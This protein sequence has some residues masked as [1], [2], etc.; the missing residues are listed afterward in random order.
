MTAQQFLKQH[1]EYGNHTK[2]FDV[3]ALGDQRRWIEGAFS[4]EDL[5]LS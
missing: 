5:I 1:P 4:V 2:R 3:I